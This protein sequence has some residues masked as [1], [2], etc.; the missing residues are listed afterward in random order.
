M[1]M[2]VAHKELHVTFLS[3]AGLYSIGLNSNN[4]LFASCLSIPHIT[5]YIL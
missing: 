1:I 2:V 4:F 3:D 5:L